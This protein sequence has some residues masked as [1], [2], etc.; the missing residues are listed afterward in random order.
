MLNDHYPKTTGTPVRVM[1]DALM[2]LTY[3]LL[4]HAGVILGLPFIVPII[5]FTRKWRK[6]FLN[7]LGFS[8]LPDSLI[9]SVGDSK[10]LKPIWIHALS[11]GEAISAVPLVSNL[12]E[13]KHNM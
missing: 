6:P 4:L 3:N 8:P 7:R 12:F 13:L 5:L 10:P 9:G 2:I 11:V 1:E